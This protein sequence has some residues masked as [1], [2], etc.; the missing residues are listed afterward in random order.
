MVITDTTCSSITGSKSFNRI[1]W[2]SSAANT[3]TYDFN[4]SPDAYQYQSDPL[5][6]E[7]SITITTDW[8][9]GTIICDNSKHVYKA[10][11]IESNIY[12]DTFEI[13]LDEPIKPKYKVPKQMRLAAFQS[14]KQHH[15]HIKQVQFIRRI[16]T[17][18]NA[19]KNWKTHNSKTR[20]I[21]ESL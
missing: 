12:C 3:T 14:E 2:G 13:L 15:Q 5:I 4:E 9:E 1:A 18:C 20:F 21:K 8:D 16:S 6:T 7:T 19:V 10:E 11:Q 17:Q